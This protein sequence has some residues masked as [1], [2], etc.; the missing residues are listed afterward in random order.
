MNW[1]ITATLKI[2]YFRR[3]DCLC[4]HFQEEKQ[5]SEEDG[6][7]IRTDIFIE[8]E[9]HWEI[10]EKRERELVE[11]EITDERRERNSCVRDS[12]RESEREWERE[13]KQ[14]YVQ[15]REKRVSNRKWTS[16]SF[17]LVR[18]RVIWTSWLFVLLFF[19][20]TSVA[21]LLFISNVSMLKI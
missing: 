4:D 9:M 1:K 5:I 19:F 21:L 12:E 3:F 10:R 11:V 16:L 13:K 6:W 18:G 7:K 8:R 14:D 17:L 20:F 2:I 15:K